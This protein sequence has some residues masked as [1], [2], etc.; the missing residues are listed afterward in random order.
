MST[1]PTTEV[2]LPATGAKVIFK[3]WLTKRESDKVREPLRRHDV[4][5]QDGKEGRKTKETVDINMLKEMEQLTLEQAVISIDGSAEKI[6]A[7]LYGDEPL[8]GD[9]FVPESDFDFLKKSIDDTLSPPKD[10]KT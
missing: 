10:Q 9:K 4:E 6:I 8:E 1:R 5:I 7:K 2:T 3:S